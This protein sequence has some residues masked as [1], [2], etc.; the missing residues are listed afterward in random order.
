MGNT[1]NRAMARI[2]WRGYDGEEV[3]EEFMEPEEPEM[4]YSAPEPVAPLPRPQ[5]VSSRETTLDVSRIVSVT[6][7][8]YADAEVIGNA[9]KDG[10][11]V[12]INLSKM[13]EAESRRIIDFAAGLAFGLSG[14]M[15]QVVEGVILLT[16]ESVRVE[17]GQQRRAFRDEPMFLSESAP[18][19]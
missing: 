6:L 14:S 3:E 17:E 2:G 11:P 13:S 4:E 9:L 10:V 1:L 18:K 7:T 12:I 16:P 19:F 8:S 15:E 5:V